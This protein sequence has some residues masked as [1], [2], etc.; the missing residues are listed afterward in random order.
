MLLFAE[1]K[2]KLKDNLIKQ[3]ITDM[4]GWFN[5]FVIDKTILNI[6]DNTKEGKAN[7]DKICFRV[8]LSTYIFIE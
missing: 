8:I 4:K 1:Y 5:Y 2:L 6:N 7:K 3:S